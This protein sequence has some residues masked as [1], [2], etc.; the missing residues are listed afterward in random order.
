MVTTAPDSDAM[1]THF[2]NVKKYS[3]P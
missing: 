3:D 2:R 1:L